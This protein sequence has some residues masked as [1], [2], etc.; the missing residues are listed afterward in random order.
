MAGIQFLQVEFKNTSDAGKRYAVMP[1]AS[2]PFDTT[3][4]Q[5]TDD[6]DVPHIT[7][8]GGDITFSKPG[9]FFV[10]WFVAQQTGLAADGANFA[11]ELQVEGSPIRVIG[12]G[13][14]KIS[15]SSGFAVLNV[16]A[17]D[18]ILTLI[19]HA[20]RKATLSE[21]TLVKAG[22]AIFSVA[23]EPEEL[24]P[25][26][27]GHAQIGTA[28]EY[29]TGDI[30]LFPTGIKYDPNDIVTYN[31]GV[32]TLANM[33]TYLVTWE[34]PIEATDEHDEVYL[35]LLYNDVEHSVSYAPLPIGVV[36]GSAL[37]VNDTV[38]GTVKLKVI[39]EG[40]PGDDIDIVHIGIKANIV[41]TQISNLIEDEPEEIPD[42]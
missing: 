18:T 30:I 12:S 16:P 3:V 42:P 2:I 15:A 8:S 19:N 24:I 20:G 37:I 26:G 10:S 22:L 13:H 9:V 32:F 17:A 29:N 39:H 5:S 4:F 25:L 11:L 6:S 23:A 21:H 35:Q 40:S 38:D 1:M 28:A 34:I 27:Y 36:S 14:V 7:Y 41:I 31:A 33:G